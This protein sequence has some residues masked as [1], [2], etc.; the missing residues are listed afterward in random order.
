MNEKN[1]SAFKIENYN[2]QLGKKGFYEDFEDFPAIIFCNGSNNKK[3][4]I[5]FYESEDDQV[6]SHVNRNNIIQPTGV[7]KPKLIMPPQISVKTNYSNSSNLQTG[8]GELYV[9][10]NQYPFYLDL[11]R[12]EDPVYAVLFEK[13]EKNKVTLRKEKDPS[14]RSGRSISDINL[15]NRL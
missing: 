9:H 10:I 6:I 4:V 13:P 1:F 5:F 12:N 15:S 3:L 2:I 14:G 7:L 8:Q 11:L